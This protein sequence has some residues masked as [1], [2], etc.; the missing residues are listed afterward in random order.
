ML[1]Q[2]QRV[3]RYKMLIEEVRRHTPA[4]MAEDVAALDEA[5]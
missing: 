1:R 4:H 2:V 5:C 3:P